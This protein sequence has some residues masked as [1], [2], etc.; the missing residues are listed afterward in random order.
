[1]NTIFN[2]TA[3]LLNFAVNAVITLA[4]IACFQ[5][6]SFSDFNAYLIC[7]NLLSG[8][9]A[10]PLLIL[11]SNSVY[12]DAKTEA[13]RGFAYKYAVAAFVLLLASAFVLVI[14]SSSAGER[15]SVIIAFVSILLLIVYSYVN[16]FNTLQLRF[17]QNLM[18]SL[19]RFMIL[20]SLVAYWFYLKQLTPIKLLI[21][22]AVSLT[23]ITLFLPNISRQNNDP[24]L[25]ID[26]SVLEYIKL[27]PILLLNNLFQV[28]H[29]YYERFIIKIFLDS[30]VY[31]EYKQVDL[32]MLLGGA[33]F[34]I[35]A[36][37]YQGRIKA[38]LEG[39]DY[40]L[41]NK[42]AKQM[43]IAF[44]IVSAVLILVF[45]LIS[46]M[47]FLDKRYGLK[48][49]HFFYTLF[50]ILANYKVLYFDIKM[51]FESKIKLVMLSN[52]VVILCSGFFVTYLTLNGWV[53][54]LGLAKAFCVALGI[55]FAFYANSLPKRSC[56]S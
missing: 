36:S 30:E 1:V 19:M 40:I 21:A 42:I 37:N 48:E 9:M 52:G 25:P 6:A 14:F 16:H 32:I 4:S 54:Y 27:V 46:R 17:D 56:L 29:D 43:M 41:Q 33:L 31:S 10:Q 53:V 8:L 5:A 13:F 12:N 3:K 50:V 28:S 23:P 26:Q 34:I 20:S 24:S 15:L 45:V 7:I 2:L 39:G 22:N 18:I 11:I 51:V 35:V 38:S 55:G 44:H 49:F 47:P